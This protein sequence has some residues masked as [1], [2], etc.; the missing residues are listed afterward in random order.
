VKT[1]LQLS[2]FILIIFTNLLILE[3]M[4]EF[5]S[6]T[7]ANENGDYTITYINFDDV[8]VTVHLN[9]FD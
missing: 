1:V 7:R 3:I 6:Q 8:L 9:L 5:I 4:K 2:V